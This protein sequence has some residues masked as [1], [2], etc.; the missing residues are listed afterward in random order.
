MC[1]LGYGSSS[2]RQTDRQT[3]RQRNKEREIERE[4]GREWNDRIRKVI[5]MRRQAVNGHF[6]G[7]L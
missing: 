3:D 4:R 7:S 1:I 6:I 5:A 2:D